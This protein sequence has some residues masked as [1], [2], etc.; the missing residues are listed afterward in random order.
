V[1]APARVFVALGSNIT[2]RGTRLAHARRMLQ[3][4]A[5]G[6]WKE[7]PIYE[8]DPIGPDGQGS[9]F[10][11]IVTFWTTFTPQRLLHF[12]KGIEL[13][14]G[15]KV[16]ARWDSREIDLDLLYCGECIETKNFILP[17]PQLHLRQFVLIPFCNLDPDW[18]DPLRACSV[19]TFLEKLQATEG[20]ASYRIVSPEEYQ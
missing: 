12:L 6:G 15:R 3:K 2:P 8:T 19:Q 16:R 14:Q 1:N 11:Q 13:V 17:H 18:M 5:V 4:A 20:V 10:N 9:Y 7:S